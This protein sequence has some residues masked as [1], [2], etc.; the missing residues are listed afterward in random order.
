MATLTNI[1]KQ[2]PIFLL[3]LLLVGSKELV[4]KVPK[5]STSPYNPI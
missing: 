3:P 1:A 4:L 5:L 2:R